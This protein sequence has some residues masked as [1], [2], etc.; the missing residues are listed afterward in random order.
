VDGKP[1]VTLSAARGLQTSLTAP[2]VQK[3]ATI[4]VILEVQDRGSPSL[5]AY[6]RAI[7]EVKP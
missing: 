1:P 6:R 3:P 7:T 5:V 4:H 2:Q